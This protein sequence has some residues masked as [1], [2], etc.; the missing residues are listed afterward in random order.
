VPA[1]RV[2]ILF[3]FCSEVGAGV[4]HNAASAVKCHKYENRPVSQHRADKVF[5]VRRYL[6]SSHKP[7][8]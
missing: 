2:V 5:S 8:Q 6:G 7:M 1:L 4:F 3:S